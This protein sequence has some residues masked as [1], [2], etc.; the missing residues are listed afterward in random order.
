MIVF[1]LCIIFHMSCLDPR[2]YIPF[3]L[4]HSMH[5]LRQTCVPSFWITAIGSCAAVGFT[6][7]CEKEDCHGNSQFC[8]CDE[9]C[10]GVGDCCNDIDDICPMPGIYFT[11]H[12]ER[13]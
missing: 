3:K 13:M 5:I 12:V 10:H 1:V 2:M 9:L 4:L 6:A 11:V 7:C 8:F